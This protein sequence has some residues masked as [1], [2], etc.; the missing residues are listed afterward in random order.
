MIVPSARLS[1]VCDRRQ[2]D[3]LDLG[4][5]TIASSVVSGFTD[6]TP[7]VRTITVGSLML[8]RAAS[9]ASS[10]P[11]SVGWPGVGSFAMAASTGPREAGGRRAIPPGVTGSAR[12]L[13]PPL[14]WRPRHP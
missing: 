6:L 5:G 9:S 4:C 2:D 14:T 1:I 8:R 11:A 3:R 13:R 7:V 12:R 10:S